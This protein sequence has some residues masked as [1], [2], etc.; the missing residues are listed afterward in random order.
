MQC[1]LYNK[2]LLSKTNMSVLFCSVV[3]FFIHR[4][5]EPER[6]VIWLLFQTLSLSLFVCLSVSFVRMSS[7]YFY[8]YDYFLCL[9]F[10]TFKL[11][12]CILSFLH[13]LF[14]S[15]LLSCLFFYF[16]HNSLSFTSLSIF[17][18]FDKKVV[19]RGFSKCYSA[20]GGT[21]TRHQKYEDYDFCCGLL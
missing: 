8:L 9:P 20:N 19:E 21:K 15:D 10:F 18:E 3:S 2:K 1:H 5:Y 13:F 11:F 7:F 16:L 4:K 14:L 6:S 17:L 12:F